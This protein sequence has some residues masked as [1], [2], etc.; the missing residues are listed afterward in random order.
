VRWRRTWLTPGLAYA[1][2]TFVVAYSPAQAPATGGSVSVASPA[3]AQSAPISPGEVVS[4][5]A[6]QK[7]AGNEAVQ[8]QNGADNSSNPVVQASE[9]PAALAQTVWDFQGLRIKAIQFLGVTFAHQ[10]TLPDELEVKIGEPLDA[11]KVRSSLRR[12]FASGR[13]KDIEVRGQRE[14]DEVTL[15]FGGVAQYYVGRIE[16]DGIKSERLSSLVEFATKLQPGTVFNDS[17][18][19]AATDGVKQVLAQAGYFEPKVKVATEKD[20]AGQQINVIYTVD[21]GPQAR[22]GNVTVEGTDFGMTP[23][24]FRSKSKLKHG[25]VTRDT[26]G[27]AL[28]NLRKYYQKRDRLEATVTLQSSTYNTQR[29]QVDYVFRANQGPTVKIVTVGTKLSTSRL[30]LLVPIY[31]EGTVD[32]DLLNESAHNIREYLQQKGLFDATSSVKLKGEGTPSLTVEFDV[33]EGKKHKVETV[34]ISGNKYFNTDLLREHMQVQKADA[35]QRSGKYSSSLL[36]A[37]S[38][39][40][41]ALYRSNGFTEAKVTTTVKDEDKGKTGQ[42]LV[43]LKIVEGEQHKFGTVTLNGVDAKRMDQVRALLNAQ[44]GQPFSLITLSGDRDAVLSYYLSHGF[45]QAKV[46]IKP[47]TDQKAA[48]IDVSLNISE[49]QQVFVQ[50][51]LVSGIR[52]TRPKVVGREIKVK[53]E[54]PLDESALLETQRNLYNLALFNEVNAAV[55]NPTGQ[56]TQKD[57][58]VQLTEAKRWDVT[59]GAGFETQTGTPGT[60][61]GQTR[62][63]TAAQNGKAGASPRVTLDISRI[64]FRGTQESITL[65]ATY[66]LLERVAT[67][68]FNNPQLLGH[69]N[70][71]AT[72]SVGYSNV[73]NIT[74]FA[75]STAQVDL[76]VTQKVKK[77]DTFIY[78]FQYREVKVDPNSLEITP[79]L[80]PQL[81][82]PVRVGGPAVTFFHDTRQPTPLDAHKGRY[83]S[84]QE[85]VASTQ[86]GSQTDFN[87]T[88]ISYST[89]YQFGKLK[90]YVLARNTRVGFEDSFGPNPNLGL[91]NCTGTLL[92]TNATCNPVPLPERLYAG[93]STSH[94]GFGIN[95]AGPRDLTTGYPVGGSSAI[96]NS[97]ELRLP[98]PTLPF[99]G[100]SISFVVFHDMGNVFQHPDEMFKSIKNF[101]QPNEKV[102]E[103]VTLAPGVSQQNGVGTCSFSYYS[104]AIGSGARYNTPVGPIRVDFSYNLNPPTYPVF[105]DYTT[106]LPYV[107]HGSHFNFFFSIGQAF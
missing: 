34:D 51:V 45:D 105:Y 63:Q 80:I 15:I 46:E 9:A 66:G 20:Q 44:S 17:D 26:T 71:T 87:K 100:N 95:A 7:K 25:K 55:Q 35:Y 41:T 103:N 42:I 106:S 31:E 54:D 68:S 30:K 76:R 78:D 8:Q 92:T 104:H 16:I 61:P 21:I 48:N 13:Y 59:Y 22:V 70:L 72:F 94:R 89:Y 83:F 43:A 99:V 88:D 79:N 73:Q 3:A 1:A 37:D 11:E 65:H 53:A 18:L 96:V 74:T 6:E 75:S 36:T 24:E 64:N 29:K 56:A 52:R 14:G 28:A 60:V 32:N 102:C 97:I 4:A 101:R 50:E 12:L 47:Q 23:D 2:L 58:L 10:D 27:N 77:A 98:P 91:A 40:I 93:G 85:F 84:I 107:G 81:S 82:E 39:A 33:D 86:F 38:E 67:L 69:K 57:V 62:G 5:E 19:T 90:K 49:G